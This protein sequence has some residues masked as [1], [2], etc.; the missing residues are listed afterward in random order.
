MQVVLK[1]GGAVVLDSAQVRMVARDIDALLDEGHHVAV[2]HGGGPQLDKALQEAG[3]AGAKLD[4]LRVTSK[5]AAAIVH[6][7][8]DGIGADLAELLQDEGLQAEHVAGAPD[9]LA[10]SVKKVKAGDLGRVGTVESFGA[11]DLPEGVPI[12]TPVGFDRRGPLNVNA[13]EGAC[14]VA[15]ALHADWLI[16]GTDV[17]AV[18]DARGTSIQSLTPAKARELIA[19]SAATGGM[20]PKLTSAMAALGH[21]V[22]R[23]LITKLQPGT[24]ADAVL[25]GRCEGTLVTE[26]RTP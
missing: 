14:A 15:A 6:K 8:M 25:E 10:A 21:G 5:A 4:G 2:V 20:I 11:K 26:E 7:V 23:V 3:E 13:D 24:L 19:T 12:I 18:R 1:L 16:L 17:S 9:R 22:R